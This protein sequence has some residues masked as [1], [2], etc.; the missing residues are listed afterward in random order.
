MPVGMASGLL[1][2]VVC[3]Q[4]KSTLTCAILLG[5][6]G[7]VFERS[8]SARLSHPAARPLTAA[9]PPARPLPPFH[10]SMYP[11]MRAHRQ[12]KSLERAKEL[13]SFIKWG[14]NEAIIEVH[15]PGPA[16]PGPA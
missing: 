3:L 13:S 12:V 4:G 9:R 10:S 6:G 1:A 16:R 14:Q 5:L 11:Q 7:Q 8:S 2:D 15:E